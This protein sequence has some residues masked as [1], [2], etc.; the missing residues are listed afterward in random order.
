[1]Q[2]KL[3]TIVLTIIMLSALMISQPVFAATPY[4]A[5]DLGTLGGSFSF[6]QDI[7]DR[8]QVAGYSSNASGEFHAFLWE[9]GS[10]TDL[11]TL[12]GTF[13]F[14]AA[15]NARGQVAGFSITASGDQHAVLWNK[16][17]ITDLGTLGGNFSS[18]SASTRVG[19]SSASAQIYPTT[20]VPSFGKVA[21]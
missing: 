9:N 11:G 15:L 16:G 3:K 12:G 5:I 20:T 19:R 2:A 21:R 18:A 14:G 4:S 10:M 17:V 13:S 7:N 8:G 6:A 1:M